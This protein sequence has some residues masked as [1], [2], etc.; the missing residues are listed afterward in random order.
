VASNPPRLLEVDRG[1]SR[2]VVGLPAGQATFSV[3]PVGEAA[4]IAG[5]Q[6]VFVLPPGS[7]R[8]R[9]VGRGIDPV[10][11]RDGRGL[12]LLAQGRRC[13]LRELRLDGQARRPPLAVP[14]STSLVADTALGL[15]VRV[16]GRDGGGADALLDPD[17]GRVQVR[18]PEIHGVVG[19]LVLW[20]DG[21]DSFVAWPA[22]S[23]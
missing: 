3:A 5:D 4:I 15:Q 14:C 2:K 22:P 21:S 17:T 8:A 1:T 20:G 6:E 10:A 7:T 11:S 16:E 9:R 13:A 19:G 18:H 23:A 12:W